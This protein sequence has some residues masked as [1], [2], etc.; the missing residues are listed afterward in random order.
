MVPREGSKV[1]DHEQVGLRW[2]LGGSAGDRDMVPSSVYVVYQLCVHKQPT[3]G[4]HVHTFHW[5][6]PGA[7]SAKKKS[8]LGEQGW[9]SFESAR[10]PLVRPGFDS[11]P[12][13][14]VGRV[15]CWFSPFSD[16]FSPGSLIFLPP[17]KPALQRPA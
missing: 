17:Q 4:R 8:V 10:L 9:R 13:P 3:A 12:M 14:Y 15:C 7:Y 16:A 2:P 6:I 5:W 11:S 1:L